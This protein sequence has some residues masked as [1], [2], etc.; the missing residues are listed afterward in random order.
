MTK[1]KN[2]TTTNSPTVKVKKKKTTSVKRK[3]TEAF[4]LMVVFITV[5][6]A[7][8]I[9]FI[10][11]A[12]SA[13]IEIEKTLDLKYT[14]AYNLNQAIF[15][16][17]K[18]SYLLQTQSLNKN[19]QKQ[20]EGR[21]TRAVDDLKKGLKKLDSDNKYTKI[22]N[23]KATALI[24]VVTDRY[25]PTL[26]N[27]DLIALSSIY[28]KDL[29]PLVEVLDKN[30]K[31]LFM[32]HL[33]HA[34]AV[35]NG[36][37]G[38]LYIYLISSICLIAFVIAILIAYKTSSY[39]THKLDIAVK[40]AYQIAK[41]D[42]TVKVLQ[43]KRRDEFG[44][45]LESL[46]MMRTSL[47]QLVSE[48]L[49]DVKTSTQKIDEI[50]TIT[51]NINDKAVYTQSTSTVIANA[52]TQMVN[53]TNEIA[54]NCETAAA[55][56]D[57]TNQDTQVGVHAIQQTI[58]GILEQ[59]KK[60]EEDAGLVSNLVKQADNIGAIVQTI[61]EI[62]AQTNLLALNAAIEAARAGDAGKGFAVVA[63]EVRALASRTTKSTKD[64]ADMV[65]SIQADA[66]LAQG[67]MQQ[68]LEH[69]QELST[70]AQAVHS[71]LNSIIDGVKTLDEEI[72]QI[73]KATVE[74]NQ[75]TLEISQ[76]LSSINE[77]ICGFSEDVGAVKEEVSQS[78]RLL[79]KLLSSVG[80][81]K[82]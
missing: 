17:N 7:L 18:N 28:E 9:V 65:G 52:A 71:L 1:N 29:Y 54:K 27:N 79:N 31:N 3:M 76:N 53:L 68:S 21:L 6:S 26:K 36:V 49:T 19:K 16:I 56:A 78:V 8:A 74:Q 64:I 75:S 22:L 45:L 81:I 23:D 43:S 80:S 37:Q 59:V 67:S 34:T 30:S 63:D 61:D 44:K 48:I 69:M 66:N 41:G 32:S 82:V 10:T 72:S 40:T 38:T 24:S 47:N 62:A 15:D 33:Y 60:S 58:D 42:T 77:N 12:N 46:E 50:D 11:H 25:L 70:K 35:V 5:I 55:N 39:I 14:F 20:L 2:T 57:K 73:A 13:V 4:S 51:G